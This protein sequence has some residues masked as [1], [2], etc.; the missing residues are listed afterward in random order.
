MPFVP[1]SFCHYL[2]KC[3]PLFSSCYFYLLNRPDPLPRCQHCFTDDVNFW[4]NVSSFQKSTA[5][6]WKHLSVEQYH[7][8]CAPHD[9]VT[10]QLAPIVQWTVHKDLNSWLQVVVHCKIQ[11]L[12]KALG[13]GVAFCHLAI[14]RSFI[15]KFSYSLYR[16]ETP[17]G[18]GVMHPPVM[19][20]SNLSGNCFG[21]CYICRVILS[22]WHAFVLLSTFTFSA[23]VIAR[24]KVRVYL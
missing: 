9:M 24:S 6:C 14:V 19:E 12:A 17:G 2:E 23:V 13:H 16:G 21:C 22:A 10:F 4:S 3:D 15:F 1:A 7:Q 18:M 20:I 8:S 11:Q 5:K